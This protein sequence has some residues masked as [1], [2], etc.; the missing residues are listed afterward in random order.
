MITGRV[1]AS[2][3]H[4]VQTS[5]VDFGYAGPRYAVQ[6]QENIDHLEDDRAG[7]WSAERLERSFAP[8]GDP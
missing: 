2:T 1:T 5:D 4:L 6:D 3:T 8:L 7:R